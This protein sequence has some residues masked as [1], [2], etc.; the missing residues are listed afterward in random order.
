MNVK[1]SKST[2][3]SPVT[4]TSTT[5]KPLMPVWLYCYSN[6][7]WADGVGFFTSYEQGFSV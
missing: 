3:M 4:G 1:K 5:E 7:N 6:K 2:N